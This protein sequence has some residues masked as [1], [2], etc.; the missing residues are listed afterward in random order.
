MRSSTIVL[1]VGLLASPLALMTAPGNPM[2]SASLITAANAQ[3][4]DTINGRVLT[5]APVPS[6][7]PPGVAPVDRF[8]GPASQTTNA[9][10][11]ANSTPFSSTP[12]GTFTGGNG[13]ETAQ[14]DRI[15]T[16]AEGQDTTPNLSR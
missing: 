7:Q 13:T 5:P 14:S 2:G 11:P 16:P 12:S 8:G 9:A 10:G 3:T 1:T 4:S 6:I 15:L